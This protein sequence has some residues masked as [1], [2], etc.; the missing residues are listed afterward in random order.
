MQTLSPSHLLSV[1]LCALFAIVLAGC[2]GPRYYADV[3]TLENPGAPKGRTV[4]IEPADGMDDRDLVYGRT[5]DRL[6][7]VL[8]AHG[9]AVVSTPAAADE[10]VKLGFAHRGPIA[11]TQQTVSPEFIPYE[12][13]GRIHHRVVYVQEVQTRLWYITNMLVS[14]T[15]R[16]AGGAKADG[17]KQAWRMEVE[18]HSLDAS[19]VNR[20]DAA[21]YAVSGALDS[22]EAGGRSFVITDLEEEK[23][24]VKE[25]TN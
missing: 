4:A 8:K 15:P 13:H 11:V 17:E 12:W 24:D 20:L 19:P 14:G 10:T 1:C 6:A 5:E 25:V 21:L 2:G 7:D 3:L 16:P 18:V 23:P 9:R 22:P